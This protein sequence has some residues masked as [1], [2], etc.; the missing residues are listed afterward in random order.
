MQSFK[1]K[2]GQRIFNTPGLGAMGYGIPA[3]IGACVASDGK[4]T[5][6]LDGDGGFIMNIQELETVKRLGLPIKFFIL[7]NEGYVSIRNTQNS[8]FDGKLIGSDKDSGLTLPD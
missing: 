7:N 4:E 5:I 8:H 1:V 3:A 6:C 2:K